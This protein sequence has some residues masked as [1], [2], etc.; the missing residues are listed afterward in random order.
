VT[1]ALPEGYVVHLPSARRVHEFGDAITILPELSVSGHEQHERTCKVCG[2]VKVTIIGHPWPR[3]W[4]LA[5][6]TEQ[7][8][9]EPV[10][11]VA[12]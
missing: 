3:A 6:G 5:G 1:D 10:C 7:V 12:A 11:R 8:V 2:A 9:S 4:R